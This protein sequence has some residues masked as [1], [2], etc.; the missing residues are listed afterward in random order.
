MEWFSTKNTFLSKKEKKLNK[1]YK[2]IKTPFEFQYTI[3]I[4]MYK[5]IFC[6]FINNWRKNGGNTSP[7]VNVFKYLIITTLRS[8][9]LYCTVRWHTLLR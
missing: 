1:L 6:L 4:Y 7:Y 9:I 2:Y 3:L 8:K 5:Y